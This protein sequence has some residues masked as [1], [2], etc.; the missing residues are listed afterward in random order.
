MDKNRL[1]NTVNIWN[2]LNIITS[3]RGATICFLWEG[4]NI[5]GENQ[6]FW[7]FAFQIVRFWF[8][9][10]DVIHLISPGRGCS[11][12]SFLIL[13]DFCFWVGG[14]FSHFCNLHFWD[15]KN[16]ELIFFLDICDI[17]IWFFLKGVW[18][19]GCTNIEWVES[20]MNERGCTE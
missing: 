10:Y 1:Y 19:S 13:N 12:N 20:Q 18:Y 4:W 7:I 9:H 11:Q 5:V 8:T 14:I 16:G 15:L 2:T 17:F 6:L 3:C